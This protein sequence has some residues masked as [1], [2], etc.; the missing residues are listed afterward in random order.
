MGKNIAGFRKRK[1]LTQETLGQMLGVNNQAVSKWESEITMPDV[2]LLP[3]IAGA[4]DVTLDDLFAE[5]ADKP[6][7][8]ESH[9]F[10]MDA[11]HRFPKEAQEWI[12]DTMYH[13]T[14][15]INCNSWDFLSVA[16]NPF[17]KKH[18]RVKARHTLSCISDTAGAA[19]V[20]DMLTLIDVGVTAEEMISVFEK[21]EVASGMKKLSDPNVRCILSHI[22]C[23]YFRCPALFDGG[24]PEAYFAVEIKTKALAGAVGLEEEALLEALEKMVAL[25]IVEQQTNTD[26]TR[27]LLH[28]IKAIETAVTFR[29]LERLI[30]NEVGFGCGAFFALIQQ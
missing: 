7:M 8:T 21:P 13:Q 25:H 9:V 24:D 4:L 27:Y 18:D 26:G 12:I 19:F 20:S 23:E 17:T 14:N 5:Y 16:Q 22:C 6:P 29:L 2:L 30:H 15:L 10:D 11:V 28:K 1:G 3:R